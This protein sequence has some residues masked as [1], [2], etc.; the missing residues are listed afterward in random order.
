MKIEFN[1]PKREAHT[2]VISEIISGQPTEVDGCFIFPLLSPGA[3]GKL[4]P[5]AGIKVALTENPDTATLRLSVK[6]LRYGN[7]GSIIE[8]ISL[9]D[10]V[11]DLKQW[12]VNAGVSL[13]NENEITLTTAIANPKAKI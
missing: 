8:E 6:S 11:V 13:T 1:Q 10:D 2:K 9:N 4:T 5:V 12:A 7:E 3:D